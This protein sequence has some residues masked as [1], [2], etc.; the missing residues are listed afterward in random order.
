MITKLKKGT[1]YYCLVGLDGNWA[2]ALVR[3][4]YVRPSRY[5]D[6]VY[7]EQ[8]I[9]GVT[10][11]FRTMASDMYP[12]DPKIVSVILHNESQTRRIID[13]PKQYDYKN[14]SEKIQ[15]WMSTLAKKDEDALRMRF[16]EGRPNLVRPDGSFKTSKFRM[17]NWRELMHGYFHYKYPK[18][19]V[20]E[21]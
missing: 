1:I 18:V 10:H 6:Y 11:Q 16:R 9:D 12:L 20:P 21:E 2:H 14:A 5:C 3:V 7:V 8:N 4:K 19:E 15:A 17:K 13:H